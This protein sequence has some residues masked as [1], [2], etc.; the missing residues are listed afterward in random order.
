MGRLPKA[1]NEHAFLK[2]AVYGKT[3]NGK[4][5]TSQAWRHSS[6]SASPASTRSAEASSIASIFPR[7]PCIQRRSTSIV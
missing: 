4:T 3:G 1:K 6:A 2:L 5:L 7:G